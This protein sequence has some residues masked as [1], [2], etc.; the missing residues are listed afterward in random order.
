[1]KLL[2]N[3]CVCGS[4]SVAT[5]LFDTRDH[6]FSAT[7]EQSWIMKCSDCGSLFPARFPSPYSLGE[8]YKA[9]YTQPKTRRGLRKILRSWIDASRAAHIIRNTPRSAHAVLDYGCGSGEFLN[10]LAEEGYKADLFG[11]DITRPKSESNEVFKW[12]SLDDYDQTGRQY[13]WITL[14]HVIEH[15]PEPTSVLNRLRACCSDS[16]GVWLSTPNTD[17]VLISAFQGHARDI[18]F[19]RHRQ[20]YSRQCLVQLLSAAGF[21]VTFLS[22]PRIDSL[23]NYASCAR[24]LLRDRSVGRIRKAVVLGGS[25]LSLA[26]HILRPAAWRLA[27]GPE[28]VVL[29]RPSPSKSLE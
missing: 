6:N 3:A 23:M 24:N 8:A 13:N 14:S 27:K 19:P 28:L 18:D 17:S 7:T 26:I 9:Y 11:T 22:S 15:L 2:A 12:L 1:M 20:I 29:A 5:Q 4:R 21:D 16:G 10:F 25:L